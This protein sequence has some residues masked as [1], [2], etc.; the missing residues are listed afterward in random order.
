M[1]II[2]IERFRT[3][4]ETHLLHMWVWVRPIPTW[5]QRSSSSTVTKISS[6]MEFSS[7]FFSIWPSTEKE[8]T[9]LGK[10]FKMLTN[11]DMIF[12]SAW[13][14]Q[15]VIFYVYVKYTFLV[16]S[17]SRKLPAQD[18]KTI[19]AVSGFSQLHLLI[20]ILTSY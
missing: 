14:Q 1:C 15:S 16:L 13:Y 7:P 8:L 9:S 19:T 3:H 6:S 11:L 2:E 4:K 12:P 5:F 20:H 10:P 18:I 17:T